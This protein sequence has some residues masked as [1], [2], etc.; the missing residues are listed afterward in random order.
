MI[1]V[2]V[3]VALV[4]LGGDDTDEAQTADISG[5]GGS[6]PSLAADGARLIRRAD[7]L[8]AEIDAPTPVP[9]TYE[10]PTG[11]MIPP[12]GRS[13]PRVVPGASDAPEVFTAWV[14]VFNAPERCTDGTATSDDLGVD[15]A[16]LGGSYQLDGLIADDET[17]AMFGRIRVGEDP[18]NGAPLNKPERRRGPRRN[19]RA[20]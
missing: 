9:G 8:V 4:L 5:Q 6:E 10:Y 3:V 13:A 2:I 11:E 16:A 19:C 18:A 15:T 12:L 17:M 14:F 7:G 1:V 20:R